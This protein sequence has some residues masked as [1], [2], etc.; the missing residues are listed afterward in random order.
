MKK[1]IDELSDIVVG[2]VVHGVR[3][4]D[5]GDLILHGGIGV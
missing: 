4:T 3:D 1:G 5:L 2:D